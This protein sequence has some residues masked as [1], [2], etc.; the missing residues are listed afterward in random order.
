[1]KNQPFKSG[2]KLASSQK[3]GDSLLESGKGYEHGQ[4]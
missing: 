2:L 3:G 1:M 4:R